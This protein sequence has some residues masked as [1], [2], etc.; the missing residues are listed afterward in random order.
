MSLTLV[1]VKGSLSFK[2]KIHKMKTVFML[3]L[4][5][6]TVL[7]NAQQKPNLHVIPHQRTTIVTNPAKGMNPYPAWGVFPS[8]DV[9]IRKITMHVTLGTPDSLPTAHWDYR[10]HIN[11]IRKGGTNG[12]SLNYEIG[13]MLTPY[14]SIY[15]TGWEFKWSVDVTDFS[16]LLRD[17]VEIEYVHTGYEPTSVGWALTIDFEIVQGPPH[18]HPLKIEPMWRGSYNYGNPEKPIEKE[19][20]PIDY[21]PES[22]SEINR[23][24]IQHTGHGM[25]RPKGCSEFCSRW[26]Q[27]LFNGQQVQKKDLWKNCGDNP[28]YPQGGTWI[29]DRALWCPGDLQ[30]PDIID[31]RPQQGGNTFAIAM[32][33]YTATDNIQA[34]E[35]ISACL[36]HYSAPVNKHDVAVEAIITP[37]NRPLYNR[38]NPKCFGSKIRIRNLGS[39]PL[40]SLKIFYYTEGFKKRSFTWKGSIAYY[41]SAD[42]ELP[43]TIQFNDH[44]NTFVVECHKPNGKKDAWKGDNRL[45]S[46]FEAPK[47]MPED[48]IVHFK[49]NNTPHENNLFLVNEAGEKVYQKLAEELVKDTLYIDTLHLSSGPYEMTLTDSAGNGLEFWF[50]KQQ[51]YG[52]V[53]L[54]DKEGRMIHNFQKDCGDGEMLAFTTT[55]KFEYSEKE[56]LSDFIVFPKM[57]VDTFDLDVYLEKEVEMEVI[58]MTNGVAVEKHIYPKTKG[59]VL[60]YNVS[61]L[62]DGRY[63]IEVY[64]N[65][66]R[67][68]KTRINKSTRRQ[69]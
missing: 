57:V 47:S 66:E 10:D 26:R 58:L 69:R 11:L 31:V 6:L 32:E 46:Q 9:P 15:S 28:L 13:R 19:L 29:F 65:G 49:T 44:V 38:S 62:P 21:A 20:L 56:A 41:E 68:Y 25:D 35:D 53:R 36:I 55:P 52:Y 22:G 48:L 18:I 8:T 67:K 63:I 7:V 40:T 37:N 61:H 30:E 16:M 23:L 34:K 24:R 2:L 54:M 50:M 42:I 64:L 27:V 4:L 51:G 45:T 12:E 5:C 17:S 33:P 3:S 59:G 39:E 43:G 60:K 1:F 14:G